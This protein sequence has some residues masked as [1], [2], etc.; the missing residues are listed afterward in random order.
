MDWLL[1]SKMED[2]GVEVKRYHKPRLLRP[3]NINHRTHRKLLVV[4]GKVGFTAGVGI[5]DAWTGRPR[6]PIIGG[7]PT[8]AWRAHASP[9][10]SAPSWTT[11][12]SPWAGCFRATFIF[13]PWPRR[14]M[15]TVRS[16]R[17]PPRA[18]ATRYGLMFL[19]AIPAASESI[20]ISTAY[21]VPGEHN[22]SHLV[23]LVSRARY[24]RLIKAGID[25]YEYRPTLYHTK[26][27]IIGGV[28]TSV[29]L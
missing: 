9:A 29:G 8:S 10:S 4:D 26:V 23:R 6:I 2:A 12:S 18:A 27:M 5:A 24:G 28:W 15:R 22:D 21:F 25:I 11:G 13:H 3:H 16:L 17:A 19:L 20:R 14:G 1:M 7:T